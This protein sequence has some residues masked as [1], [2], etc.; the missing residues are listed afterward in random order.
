MGNGFQICI[1]GCDG[2][3]KSAIVIELAKWIANEIG[4]KTINT[5][6]PGST[7]LGAEL[8]RIIAD[9]ELGVDHQARALLFAADNAAYISTILIPKM[10]DDYCVVADRNNFISSFA[11]QIADGCSLDILKKIHSATY[12]LDLVPK[13]DILF[14]LRVSYE[15]AVNRREERSSIEKAEHFEKKMMSHS[16]FNRVSCAYDDLPNHLEW[17]LKFVKAKGDTPHIVYIDANRT[18]DIVLHDVKEAIR[19]LLKNLINT[20][21]PDGS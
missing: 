21:R 6:H 9:R 4:I 7:L 18:F 14:I 2:S 1:E 15:T 10:K 3:G 13:I 20:G 17:L 11:Y 5:R 19:P 12:N 16:F 8:R